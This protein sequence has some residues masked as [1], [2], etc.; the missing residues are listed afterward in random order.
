L[1]CSGGPG[2]DRFDALTAL[3]N[4]VD[5]G[6]APT[7]MVAMKQGSSLSRPICAFPALPRYRGSGDPNDAA[8]FE[9]R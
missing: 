4:W 8:S 1:H 6:V 5:R 7:S 3:E 2:P 9:C